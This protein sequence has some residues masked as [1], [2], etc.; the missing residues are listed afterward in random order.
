MLSDHTEFFADGLSPS[1]ATESYR[2]LTTV[3]FV[4]DLFLDHA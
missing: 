3:I 2:N 4:L 1:K